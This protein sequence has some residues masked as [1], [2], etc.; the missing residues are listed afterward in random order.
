MEGDWVVRTTSACLLRTLSCLSVSDIFCAESPYFSEEGPPPT[1]V[2]CRLF[3]TADWERRW[4]WD[5]I[6]VKKGDD[7]SRD[8]RQ[9]SRDSQDFTALLASGTFCHCGER[10]GRTN[11]EVIW[12][13]H[14]SSQP[15][16]AFDDVGE[17][18]ECRCWRWQWWSWK[19][20]H[21]AKRGWILAEASPTTGVARRCYVCLCH[22]NVCLVS[23][24]CSQSVWIAMFYIREWTRNVHNF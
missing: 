2:S 12:G 17:S 6:A 5:E 14:R 10:W 11:N 15:A 20:L 16:R 18:Q 22:R 19:G 4:V 3:A 23:V 21:V 1:S 7:G 8:G 9:R 13:G 24:N